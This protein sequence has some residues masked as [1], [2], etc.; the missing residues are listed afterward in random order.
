MF[1]FR[2]TIGNEVFLIGKIRTHFNFLTFSGKHYGGYVGNESN[3]AGIYADHVD[4]AQ[5]K[6]A[7]QN[8]TNDDS[9][10]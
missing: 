4:S 9:G 1:S 10:A 6:S 5:I 7:S 3:Q 2:F 8:I